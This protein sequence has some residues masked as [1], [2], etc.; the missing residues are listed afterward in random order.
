MQTVNEDL[1]REWKIRNNI[2]LVS[3]SETRF[4]LCIF[5]GTY[6]DRQ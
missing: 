4:G 6:K 2:R 3:V 1:K 5:A